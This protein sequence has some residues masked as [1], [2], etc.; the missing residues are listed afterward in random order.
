M[1][2]RIV[3]LTF[4]VL[5]LL[6]TIS[7][8]QTGGTGA[9]AAENGM[10]ST[11]NR[12][13]TLA[14]VETLR[15]GGNAVDAAAV[16]QFVLNVTE[17][18][19]SGIGGGLF[20]L[21]YDAESGEVIAIDGREEAPSAYTPDIFLDDEGNPTPFGERV[22]GG[23]PVGV[24]GTLAAIARALDEYGTL[25]LAEALA[26]AIELARDGFVIDDYFA[27]SALGGFNTD[28]IRNF[29][30]TM[31][32]Y[33][34]DDGEPLPAGSVI[35]NPDLADTLQLIADEGIEVFYGGEIGED[36]VDAVQNAPFNPGVMSIEDL[37]GYRAV[38]R[39]PVTTSYRGYDVYGM[40]MPTSGGTSMMLML[41][42]LEGFDL[43]SMGFGSL[44]YVS[45]LANAQN[46]AF[47]DRNAYMADADFVDV[48]VAGLT[49]K[50]YARERRQLMLNPPF[51]A[52]STPVD[53]GDPFA[54]VPEEDDDA[55]A[56][57][58]PYSV[59]AHTDTESVSTTHFSVVDGERNLVSITSTIELLF[60]SAMVVPGRG[61]LLNNELTDFSGTPTDA[62]GNPIANA[63]SGE[64][65][66]R[67]TA[68]GDD[69]ETVGGK[70]PRSSM[71]PTLVLRDGEPFMALGS[72]GGSRII[73]Y[74]L[75]VLLHVIDFGMELQEAVNVGRVV[76]R[77]GS[78]NID[79]D[80]LTPALR[81][82][83]EAR[84][85]GV[86]EGNTGSLQ[87]VL[88]GDDGMVYGAA[89]PRRNGLA[90]GH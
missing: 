46:L 72:P 54:Y 69:A 76:A 3:F 30:A 9:T 7:L 20:M 33:F 6:P 78:V 32:I 85:F 34:G 62:D 18:Y 45:T 66:E 5:A 82:G 58:W 44:E 86:N 77:N 70:R 90:L 41:N 38:L 56:L 63:P 48:P 73:G 79:S 21:I 37:E 49:S 88:V 50:A 31:E 14:G 53:V 24:P 59:A 29:P 83:L 42:L 67:R 74:N 40:N 55:A 10:V 1:K 87:A 65:A 22:T 4:L 39:E 80:V 25:T 17:P 28:R 15:Q 71:A 89:D 61:F 57:D 81:A 12:Y 23:N 84:G 19:A 64:R 11:S 60:G 13:A 43:G 8:A 75:N 35:T 26:P 2:L 47:A 27:E 36:I 51:S 16:V 52:V 68:L